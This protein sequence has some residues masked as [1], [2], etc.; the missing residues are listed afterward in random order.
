MKQ[1]LSNGKRY[2]FAGVQDASTLKIAHSSCSKRDS[3][4]KARGRQIALG[5]LQ[6]GKSIEVHVTHEITTKEFMDITSKLV[7]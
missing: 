1:P 3:F 5:R 2:T 7:L 4:E 6:K